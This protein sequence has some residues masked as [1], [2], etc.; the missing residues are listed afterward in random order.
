MP[1]CFRWGPGAVLEQVLG[2][3]EPQGLRGRRWPGAHGGPQDRPARGMWWAPGQAG[4]G[5]SR[6][7]PVPPVPASCSRFLSGPLPLPLRAS[8][9]HPQAGAARPMAGLGHVQPATTGTPWKRNGETT[10]SSVTGPLLRHA[11]FPGPALCTCSQSWPHG[12][13]HG[14]PNS[15]S[16][17]V[18]LPGRVCL[19]G[20]SWKMPIRP[21]SS[22]TTLSTAHPAG[23]HCILDVC[24][25]CPGL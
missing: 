9:L 4:P 15:L 19:L 23:D 8:E 12:A 16:P 22:L 1:P 14:P 13:L 5:P 18:P 3:P 25:T 7:A 6:L 24:W 11:G 2:T 20:F 17:T 21:R 10:R